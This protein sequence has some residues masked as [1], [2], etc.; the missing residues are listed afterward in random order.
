M[1]DL[2]AEPVRTAANAEIEARSEETPEI[3]LSAD[4]P[5][6]E[7]EPVAESEPEETKKTAKEKTEPAPPAEPTPRAVSKSAP[8]SS[9]P[10]PGDRTVIDGKPYV[11]IPGFGWIKDEGGGSVCTVVGSPDDELAGNNV[12]IMGGAESAPGNTLP[13]PS[14][15]P[16]PTGDE[17]YVPILPPVTKDSTPPPYKPNGKPINP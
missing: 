13:P 3:L 4:T 15:E 2:P 14:A 12:G 17:I 9:E 6:P 8:V 16:E 7:P 5:T 10:K 11:W 1:E